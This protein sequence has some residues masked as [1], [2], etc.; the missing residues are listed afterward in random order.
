MIRLGKWEF[1]LGAV[2]AA[3]ALLFSNNVLACGDCAQCKASKVASALD[4]ANGS[5]FSSQAT[6]RFGVLGDT[7]GLQYVEQ[8]I[9]DMNAHDPSLVIF[10]GDLVGTGSASSWG[11]WNRRTE[12]FVGGPNRRL[13]VPGNHD[14]PVGTDALWQQTFDWL[15]DSQPFD[16]ETGIDKMDYIY[17]FGN[18]RFISVTTDSQAFGAGG[19]PAAMPW[20]ENVLSDPST[21]SKDHVFVYSHHPVTFNNYDGTGGTRGNWWQAMGQAGNVAGLFVGHWHQYQPSQPHP[22]HDTW[23]VISGTGNAGFSGHPWQNKIG[24][25]IVEVQGQRAWLKF[26]GDA[27]GD[28]Q[29]DDLLDTF[30]MA[31]PRPGPAGVVAYYG[32]E[33][34]TANRDTALSELA[35]ANTGAYY[36]GAHIDAQGAMGNGLVL[37]G[38]DDYAD[39]RGIGD[40]NLAILGDLT[41]AI[42]ANYDQLMPGAGAN[43]LISYTADVA[44]F[45]DREEAVNQPYNLRIRSDQH[46]E[47]FW[48]RDN[49]MREVFVSTEPANIISGQWHDYRV[50][51][52]ATSG[53][54][55]FFVDGA[56]LGD[57]LSFD[58]LTELPTGGAQGILRM[59]INYDRNAATKLTG[60]FDGRLDELAIWN[61]VTLETYTGPLDGDLNLDGLLD[62]ADIH[63]FIVNWRTVTLEDDLLSR[64]GKGDLDLNG[65][66][67]LLDIVIFQRALQ[68]AGLEFPG[69]PEPCGSLLVFSCLLCLGAGRRHFV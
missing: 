25:S 11:E 38:N 23:E 29:Y 68:E 39:G 61:D 20:L 59:G 21:Q 62:N 8:L 37:D 16:G 28:G 50:T 3:Q 2:I 34:S 41:L 44:G 67:D 43:T 55:Q 51:R 60:A 47:F 33:D 13:M 5:A 30:Q 58:P 45:T 49:N 24:Y 48:E 1:A 63:Q 57:T 9:T 31:D 6:F 46:L 66:S 32:F 42:S 12:H 4:A 19:S 17:D 64:W 69:I 53:E 40:Y 10:P 18:T 14:L 35:K 27:D 56:P 22:H 36:R 7:Q 15:P 52:D 26:Y 65:T 54:I